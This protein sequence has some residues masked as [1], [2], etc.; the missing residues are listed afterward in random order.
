SGFFVSR[1]ATVPAL[2]QRAPPVPPPPVGSRWQMKRQTPRLIHLV[3]ASV[4]SGDAPLP[5][6]ISC[7]GENGV[8]FSVVWIELTLAEAP[9]LTGT[10]RSSIRPHPAAAVCL[11]PPSR[12]PSR[13][14]LTP[15]SST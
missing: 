11:S 4:T 3:G 2:S 13:S 8:P 7:G 12:R 14:A 5:G 10:S 1:F 9:V 15:P 6:S